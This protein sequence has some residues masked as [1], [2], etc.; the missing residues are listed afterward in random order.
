M[1]NISNNANNNF[2]LPFWSMTLEELYSKLNSSELGLTTEE[3]TK[4]QKIYGKNILN[5]RKRNNTLLIFLSQFKSPIIIILIIA[6]I[7]S[8]F[9][10]DKNDAII[11]L[12]II[13][14]SGFLG[15]WQEK[16]AKDAVEKLLEKVQINTMVIRDGKEVEISSNEIVPGDIILL[17]AGDIIPGDLFLISSKDLY[18]NE[19]A[20][21]G[22]SFPT[23]KFPS[24]VEKDAVVS[25]R[26]NSLFMGTNVVSGI[27]KALVINTGKNTI[28]GNISEKLNLKPSENSFEL[29]IKKFGYLLMEVTIGLVLFIFTVNI[30]LKKPIMDSFLFSLALAVGLTPQLLPAIISINLSHGARKMA[31][32]KVIVKKLSSIENFGSMNVLC[33]DKTGTLTEGQ[34]RVFSYYDINNNN[35]NDKISLYSYLNSFYES[36]YNSPIDDAI[37]NF[38]SYNIENYQKL[39]EIPYDFRRKRLSILVKD[40]KEDKNILITKGALKEILS[41]SKFVEENKKISD[42]N[43]NLIDSINKKFEEYGN[44]GYKVIGI[45]YRNLNKDIIKI[46]RNFEDQM[47]F[48]GFILLNDP[49]KDNIKQNIDNLKKLGISLKII[50]G[51]NQFVARYIAKQLEIDTENIITGK[52][53][54][55]LSDSA[56][57][58]KVNDINI[59]TEVEPNHKERIILALKKSG[60]VVGYIGDGINDAT[61]IYNADVG[62]SVNNAVD[63]AKNASDIILLE[64]DLKVLEGGVLEGR[65]TFANTM[66]YIFMATSANFGNMFSMAGASIF[67]KFLPLLPT[68]ILLTNLFTDVSEMTIATDNIDNEFILSPKKWNIKFILKFMLTFGT[69]SSIFDYITFGVLLLLLHSNQ[70]VFRTGWFIESVLSASIIVL[71][72]RTKNIFYKSKPGKYLITAIALT[73]LVTVILP[74]T[75]LGAIFG[76]TKLPINFLI[77]VVII[78]F[79]YI[80]LAE[81]TKKIFYKFVDY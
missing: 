6:A 69:L 68:Q 21:T 55:N 20:L 34:I 15:F 77:I 46:D 39:D 71:V 36:G 57:I 32:N 56:L 50:T 31:E 4:R 25:K 59:F 22:E 60:N 30:F 1:K 42:L 54:N 19:A 44:N 12:I 28:F 75:K 26:T 64:K 7:L 81:I 52:E 43:N 9:L 74:Y 17:N 62:I 11:I 76:F 33:S 3:A 45:C 80:V 14:I 38:K 79:A 41:I 53:L 70:Y 35:T 51:D 10:K 40:K 23:N 2:S 37:K 65:K 29:G 27:A 72:I 8:L 16:G 5:K 24:I 61:A 67:L 18:V 63:V 66:K 13:F 49:L 73:A 47:I 48:L 78:I 58:R